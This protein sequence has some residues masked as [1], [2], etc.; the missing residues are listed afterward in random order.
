MKNVT[1]YSVRCFNAICEMVGGRENMAKE[2]GV[3]KQTLA[4]WAYERRISHRFLLK[5]VKLGEGK[6][7]AEELLGKFDNVD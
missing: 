1:P 5:L 7:S 6:F 3:R 4:N 2:L